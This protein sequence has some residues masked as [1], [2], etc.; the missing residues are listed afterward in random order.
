MTAQKAYEIIKKEQPEMVVIECLA[1]SDFYAFGLVEKGKEN[2]I[3][4]GGYSTVNKNS[5]E[6]GEFSPP[7]DFEA[8]FAA[9][10]IDVNTLS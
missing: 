1:F 2:E 10:A 5:G 9:K 6:I 7:Q 4:G 8:F 3:S